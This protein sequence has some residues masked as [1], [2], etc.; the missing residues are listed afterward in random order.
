MYKV[1]LKTICLNHNEL[2]SNGDGVE[3]NYTKEDTANDGYIVG[4]LF[5]ADKQR[6]RER[7]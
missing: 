3:C 6:E 7:S 5:Y 2:C 4:I 1:S